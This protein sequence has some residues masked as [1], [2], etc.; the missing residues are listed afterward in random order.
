MNLTDSRDFRG[1]H[2]LDSSLQNKQLLVLGVN[3][4]YPEITRT[5]GIKFISYARITA[6]YRYFL[7][8]VSPVCGEWIHRFVYQND[9]TV[10]EDLALVLSKQDLQF[11]KRLNTLNEGI[12]DSLKYR[13]IGIDADN[14]ILM[15]GLAINS[16][17]K[18]KV[19]PDRLR[20]PIEAMQSALRYEQLSLD[21]LDQNRDV[22]H[23]LAKHTLATFTESFDTLKTV[24]MDWLGD[25]KWLKM[26][27]YMRSLKNAIDYEISLVNTALED[28]FRV[29]QVSENIRRTLQTFP[30]EKFIAVM[31]RCFASS[32][33]LQGACGLHNFSPVCSKLS[34]DSILADKFFNTGVYYNEVADADDEPESIKSALR[35][36]RAGVS[37]SAVSLSVS[38]QTKTKMPFNYMLVMGNNT[39]SFV[40]A[41]DSQDAQKSNRF[42]S[43]P[44]LSAGLNSGIHLVN[45]FKLNDLMK[46]YGLPAAQI[47]P[48]HG[49][50]FS[51]W[52]REN[53]LYEIGFFQRAKTSG[54]AYHYWGTYLSGMTTI[55][56]P[57]SWLKGGLG[58]IISYQQ[59]FV[60]NPY[61]QID[62]IFIS[63][64]TMPT[65]AVNPVL[66]MGLNAK[67]MITSLWGAYISVEAGY[68]WDVSNKRWRVNNSYSGPL[69]RF[70]GHQVYF[71]VATGI[72]LL[73]K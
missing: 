40:S 67:V 31:G 29:K 22:N 62:T 18:D 13:I 12:A 32:T 21:T 44:L 45:I 33:W 7:A 42:A 60:N 1:M 50:H 56:S 63:R 49:I 30:K 5:V 23:N 15:T 43:E 3:R 19:P 10:L 48:D 39:D 66:T 57:K 68:G 52:D 9:Q 59:H 64:Y 27:S 51:A 73:K 54:S 65:T 17:V 41:A 24:Y 70:K 8:P 38:D 55:F 34:E 36:I 37:E 71:N 58:S 14:Q 25:E 6:G 2:I 46:G 61:T 53:N 20:I 69:D 72:H 35:K 26:E 4:Y 16:L 28:P 47:I 11:Y